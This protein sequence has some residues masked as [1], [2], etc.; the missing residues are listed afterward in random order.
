MSRRILIATHTMGRRTGSE[1]H[2]R[3]LALGLVRR[4]H[5]CAIFAA[6][7]SEDEDARVLRRAG[8][9]LAD[10]L[11]DLPWPPDVIHGHHRSETLLAGATFPLAPALQVCHDAT[12]PRD[13]AGPASMVQLWC[14]VD[15]FCRERVSRET[16]L[17]AG[18]I[19]LLANAVDLEAFPAR[20]LPPATPPRKALFFHSSPREM[21]AFEAAAAACADLGI[22][23]DRMGPGDG[24]FRASPAGILAETD[25]VFAKAR[26]ALEAMAA[27]CHVVLVAHEGVG[28]AVTAGNFDALRRRNFGRS[29]LSGPLTAAELAARVGALDR[30]GTAEV[31]GLVRS[32]CGLGALA[33]EAEAL[34]HRLAA[35]EVRRGVLARLFHGIPS[36]LRAFL[37]RTRPKRDRR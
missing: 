15:E 21:P 20:R 14:A 12:Q 25:L 5:A 7:L 34:H 27:G 24:K 16:G 30:E 31:T 37:R 8:V 32:R 35:A 11:S 10:R 17:P 1:V 19:P 13:R 18:E 26:C 36:W 9:I 33:A 4:G 29:I 3:D 22:A 6:S 2:T 23:L 28:P